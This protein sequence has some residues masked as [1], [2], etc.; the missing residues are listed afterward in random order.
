MSQQA[1][2]EVSATPVSAFCT[3]GAASRE[4]SVHYPPR[5][6]VMIPPD[7]AYIILPFQDEFYAQLFAPGA[8]DN[9]EDEC[10]EIIS[11]YISGC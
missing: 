7:D 11:A 10:E 4:S 8:S 3:L 5:G 1:L 9:D 6:P 2:G